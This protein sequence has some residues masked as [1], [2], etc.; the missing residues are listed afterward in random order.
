[1]IKL[2]LKS[3]FRTL[4]YIKLLKNVNQTLQ[5]PLD[6]QS[7]GNIIDYTVTWA[8]T[9]GTEQQNST[10]V[11]HSEHHVELRLDTAEEYIVSVTARNINGSSSPSTITI[12]RRNSGMKPL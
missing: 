4:Q 1:M 12:S 2:L 7:H 3:L 6:N 10:T 8:K 5:M 11:A 9:R